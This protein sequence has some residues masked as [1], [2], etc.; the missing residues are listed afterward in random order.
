MEDN[1]IQ[2]NF[3]DYVQRKKDLLEEVVFRRSVFI[4]CI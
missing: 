2:D 3:N 4:S 1:N